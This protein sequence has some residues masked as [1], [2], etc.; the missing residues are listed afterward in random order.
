[1]QPPMGDLPRKTWIEPLVTLVQ[2]MGIFHEAW[3]VDLSALTPKMQIWHIWKWVKIGYP[4][5]I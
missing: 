2:K 3:G 4:L 5:V 1:M